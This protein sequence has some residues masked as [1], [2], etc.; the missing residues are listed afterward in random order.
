M[1]LI[2][3]LSP[4]LS[5]GRGGALLLHVFHAAELA[6]VGTEL[7]AA[8]EAG[9]EAVDAGV[10]GGEGEGAGVAGAGAEG[11]AEVAADRAEA[12]LVRVRAGEGA[13][14]SGTRRVVEVD[15]HRDLRAVLGHVEI[16]EDEDRSVG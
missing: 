12:T 9:A 4:A 3:T 8:A 2:A 6:V 13:R 1:T 10:D 11:A 16:V 7:V 15:G 5:Q 14:G